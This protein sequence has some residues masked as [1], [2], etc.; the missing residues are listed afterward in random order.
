MAWLKIRKQTYYAIW[1]QKGKKVVATTGIKATKANKNYAQVTADGMENVAK[2]KTPVEKAVEALRKTA[3]VMGMGTRMPTVKELLEEYTP[4]GGEKNAKNYKRATKRFIDFLGEKSV[5]R[6]DTLKPSV[7]REFILSL[8]DKA[9][10]GTIYQYVGQIKTAFSQAVRDSLLQS[11]PWSS[12]QLAKLVPAENRIGTKRLPFTREEMQKLMT[13]FP[14]PWKEI[15]TVSYLTG[16]QR[17]GDIV[18]LKWESIDFEN[19]LIRFYTQKT[20]KLLVTPMVDAVKAA[21]KS[22]LGRDDTYVFPGMHARYVRGS[23]NVSTEFSALLRS[24]GIETHQ[25][26]PT[27]QIRG[28]SQKSFHSIRHAAVTQLRSNNAFSPDIVR[29]VVGHDCEA[30][31]RGYFTA[32]LEQKAKA[33]NYLSENAKGDS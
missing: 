5:K 29:E 24:H 17:L 1:K 19:N 6:A 32:E 26:D 10:Y 28:V 7:C 11:N 21:L 20:A 16:G 25:S 4:S 14:S 12:V 13:E 23:G 31:E 18:C 9:A 33:L 22:Q 2:G 3:E 8:K 27:G 15:V 30:I